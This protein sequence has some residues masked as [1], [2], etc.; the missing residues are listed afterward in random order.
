VAR[1][2]I[3]DRVQETTTTAGPGPLT[4]AG[5]AAGF[6]AFAAAFPLGQACY[7]TIDDDAGGWE[8]GV[9]H[10]SAPTV[11]VRDRVLESSAGSSF[12]SFGAGVKRVYCSAPAPA[13]D[14]HY[15]H[16]QATPATTWTI[17]HGLGKRAAVEVVDSAGRRVQGEV[18]YV[19]DDTVQVS[20]TAAFGGKA[21]L[22]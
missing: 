20:F 3:A 6:R 19:D 14:A 18:T 9:G 7:Y 16:D 4:L 15:V 21:Y 5:A 13:F 10:L 22:N 2:L 12:V 17:A 11:L 1:P 8:D